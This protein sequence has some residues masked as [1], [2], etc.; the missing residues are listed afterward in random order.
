[1]FGYFEIHLNQEYENVWGLPIEVGLKNNQGLICL[2]ADLSILEL[3]LS[4]INRGHVDRIMLHSNDSHI[5]IEYYKRFKETCERY[6]MEH[7]II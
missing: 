1:M 3:L 2:V 6:N 4:N 5:D 7:G